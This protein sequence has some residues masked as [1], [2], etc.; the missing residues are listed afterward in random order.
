MRS[1]VV[2]PAPFG[3]DEREPVAAL[4]LERD[5]VEE[6]LAG[7]LLAQVGCDHDGHADSELSVE[8]FGDA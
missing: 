3:P 6:R 7:E 2:L 4:D 5:A 1:S 8:E